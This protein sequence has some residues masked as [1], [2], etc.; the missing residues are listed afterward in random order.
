MFDS[1]DLYRIIC[2]NI[3]KKPRVIYDNDTLAVLGVEVNNIISNSIYYRYPLLEFDT[4]YQ[5]PETDLIMEY[6]LYY[7]YPQLYPMDT[8]SKNLLNLS[9]IVDYIKKSNIFYVYT[10]PLS[11]NHKLKTFSDS[12]EE[13]DSID[14]NN[15]VIHADLFSTENTNKIYLSTRQNDNLFKIYEIITSPFSIS[16]LKSFMGP[17]STIFSNFFVLDN[18]NIIYL[19]YKINETE[20]FIIDINL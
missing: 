2:A 12:G 17:S 14:L 19:L 1:N 20:T 16:E 8:I 5:L 6:P 15:N 18:T 13:I 7:I 11:G 10:Q 3:T 4:I 9:Y